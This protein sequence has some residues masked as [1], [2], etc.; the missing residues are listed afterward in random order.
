M[1]LIR[2][3]LA[4]SLLLAFLGAVAGA[5]LASVL[6]QSLVSFLSTEGSQL[7]LDLQ[8][9]WRVLGFTAGLAVLTTVLFGLAP[10][11]RATRSAPG[12]VLKAGGRAMTARVE[13]DRKLT[14]T[15]FGH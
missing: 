7:F 14:Q 13:Q 12:A 6:S 5:L 4:E 11:L 15:L 8:P 10:A 2:Q 3:L 9:D 1:R